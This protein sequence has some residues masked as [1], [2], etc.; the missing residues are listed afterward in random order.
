MTPLVV[1]MGMGA[2][3]FLKWLPLALLV[4]WVQLTS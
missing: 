1:T 2:L 4:M 3:A